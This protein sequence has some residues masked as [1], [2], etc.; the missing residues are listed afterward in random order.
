MEAAQLTTKTLEN[1]LTKNWRFKIENATKLHKCFTLCQD[2]TEQSKT[3]EI[4]IFYFFRVLTVRNASPES[5]MAAFQTCNKMD[6]LFSEML[7]FNCGLPVKI[8]KI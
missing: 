3:I 1:T 8:R 2:K 6:N 4:S 7:P 5:R